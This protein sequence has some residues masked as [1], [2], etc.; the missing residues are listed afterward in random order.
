MTGFSAFNQVGRHCL[1]QCRPVYRGRDG[2]A[3]NCSA[4]KPTPGYGDGNEL[5]LQ[6]L[7]VVTLLGNY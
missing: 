5:G 2:S 7:N 1:L 3:P 6:G 4:S